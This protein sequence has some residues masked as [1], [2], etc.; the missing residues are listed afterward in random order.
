MTETG[1]NEVVWRPTR[2]Y[3]ERTRLSRFMRSLGVAS[4]EELQRRS[5]ADPD[6]Y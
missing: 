4:L 3:A 6:W 5:V 2:E 1:T